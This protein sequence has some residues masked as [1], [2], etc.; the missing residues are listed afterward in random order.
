MNLGFFMVKI[1][2]IPKRQVLL[3]GINVSDIQVQFVSLRNIQK[4]NQ[5]RLLVWGNIV[6]P[7]IEHLKIGDYIIIKGFLS[8]RQRKSGA[9]VYNQ[10]KLTLLRVYPFLLKN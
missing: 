4:P 5:M 7:F 8:F 2:S 1:V 6:K 3:N 9:F 10:I